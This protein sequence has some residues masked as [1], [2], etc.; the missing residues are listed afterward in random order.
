MLSRKTLESLY[1]YVV[2][3]GV[4]TLSADGRSAPPAASLYKPENG[5]IAG[6]LGTYAFGGCTIV[7]GLEG[8][9]LSTLGEAVR[10][11]VNLIYTDTPYGFQEHRELIRR[12]AEALRN[13]V[14]QALEEEAVL[15]VAH[16]V[17]HVS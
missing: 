16:P 6:G 9:Y 7:R 17:Y 10:D 13:A 15:V 14:F 1:Y 8:S 5:P 3:V 11:R 12:Y 4:S 2:V